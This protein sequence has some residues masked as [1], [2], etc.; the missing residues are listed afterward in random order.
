MD[1]V[2]IYEVTPRD[3]L[4]NEPVIVPTD[5]KVELIERLVDAGYRDIEVTSFVKPSWIPQLADG[6][7]V[8]RRLG[9]APE[10]VRYW[11]LIPNRRGL[12]RALDAGVRHVATFMSASETHNRKNV[13]RTRRE[14]LSAL[15]EVIATAR[16]EG[17]TVRA[18]LSTVFG[19]PYEG[20]VDPDATVEIIQQLSAAGAQ[21]IALGD[22]TGMGNPRQ[23]QEIIAR[24]VAAGIPLDQIA[25]HMHDT[26]GTALANALAGY[27]AGVRIFDGS[28]A[29]VGGCP[30]A[31]GAAGNAATE[32]LVH[33]FQ[34]MGSES[35]IDLDRAAEVG[36][37]LADALGRELTGRY[38]RYHL[39][40]AER[41]ARRAQKKSRTTA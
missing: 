20:H 15:E 11:A 18:Y 24:V 25:L 36:V 29:G 31:P 34:A 35:P 27:Q 40:N 7:E 10:G 30:Y 39:G 12:D 8:F 21:E 17:Q 28:T 38:H 41:Q 1:P 26:R 37:F 6:V 4:Q 33:M 16:A 5:A 3:G 19:C 14:S 13:N 23:V 9:P 32:D 2:R 22:T